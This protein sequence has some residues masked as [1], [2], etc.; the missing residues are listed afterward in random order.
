MRNGRAEP[1]SCQFC[2]AKKLRCNRVHPCSNCAARNVT[3]HFL[4][5]PSRNPGHQN[6]ESHRDRQIISRLERLESIVLAQGTANEE[7]SDSQ[8]DI[9][10]TPYQEDSSRYKDLH[11]LENVGVREDLLVGRLISL[12]FYPLPPLKFY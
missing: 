10:S 6:P 4:V 5:P 3:C 8:N 7:L 12:V 2:R 1:T 9:T 11:T